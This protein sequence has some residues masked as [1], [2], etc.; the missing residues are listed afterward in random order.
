MAIFFQEEKLKEYIEIDY[1]D[2]YQACGGYSG[3]GEYRGFRKLPIEARVNDGIHWG[4][5]DT[6]DRN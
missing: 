5:C 3:K 4:N 2:L 1:I 6:G